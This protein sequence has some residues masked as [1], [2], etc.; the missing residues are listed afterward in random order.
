MFDGD[1]S[2]VVVIGV[3]PWRLVAFGGSR[4]RA[5][6][7][8]VVLLGVVWCQSDACGSSSWRLAFLAGGGWCC[9]VAL[10]LAEF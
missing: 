8:F 9:V 10:V 6:S 2:R 7:R 1:W 3:A 5:R 4:W